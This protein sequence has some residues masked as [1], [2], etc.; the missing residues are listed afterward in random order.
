MFQTW[1]ELNRQ[2]V[3]KAVDTLSG[4]IAG[5]LAAQDQWGALVIPFFMLVVNYAWFWFDNQNKVTV[6]GLEEAGKLQTAQTV[7]TALKA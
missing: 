3:R 5:W 1:W 7:Q 4:A 6:K 2:N